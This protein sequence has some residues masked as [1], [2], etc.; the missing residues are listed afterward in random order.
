MGTSPQAIC[1]LMQEN[2][3]KIVTTIIWL[4]KASDSEGTGI[5][6]MV[7]DCASNCD[8]DYDLFD[9]D[10]DYELFIMIVIMI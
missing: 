5:A 9:Y 2:L 7:S 8:Y 6:Y 4:E 10:C 1:D 3:P